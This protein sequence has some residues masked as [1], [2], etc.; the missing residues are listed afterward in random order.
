MTCP[1]FNGD[2]P[3]MWRANCEVYFDVY[4]ILPQNWVKVAT[5]N[6]CG[7]AA[8]WLQSVRNQLIGI[9]WSDLCEKVCARFSRD[10][11]QALIRQWIHIKQNTSVGDYVERFDSVMHQ[12][13]A[14]EST[15]P[16]I[17]F[18]TKFME[19]LRDDI[20]SMVM[21]QRPQDL[22]SACSLA[23]LQEEA[24]GGTKSVTF[25]NVNSP[26]FVKSPSRSNINSASP[27]SSTIT[28]PT[29]S[30]E[31]KRMPEA[32][33]G[34][35]DRVAALK[36]Y[37]RSKGLCFTCG[38]KWGRDHKC[39]TSV[40]LHVVEELLDALQSDMDIISTAGSIPEG[41]E[42]VLMSISAQALHGTETSKSNRL[43][44]WIQDKEM[45]ML[46]D[47]GSTH[48]F[49][50]EQISTKLRGVQTLTTP[51]KVQ[52]ADGGQLPCSQVIPHCSWW[53]QGNNFKT[54][55]RLL[56]LGSYDVILGMDW[57][58][59][60]SP[61][62]ID[63]AK[64]WLEFHYQQ[65]LIRLKGL[66]P[67]LNHCD[68]ISLHQLTGMVATE[69]VECVLQLQATSESR[70]S[71]IP[72][73]VQPILKEFQ[74]L[75]SEPT[76]LPPSRN[77]D[78]HIPL[79]PGAKPVNLRPYRYKPALKNEIERQVSEMLESGV[80]QHSQSP[81]SS[82]ALLV[83]KK[84]GTWRLC[85]DYRQLNAITVKSK[86]PVP[87]IEELL[88]ELSGSHWFS[89]LDLRAG[90]H[91]IRMAKGDEPKTAFQTHS[92]HYEYKVMSFGLTGAPATFLSAMN[93]TLASVLR[94]FALVFFD[95]I[96]IYSPTLS[97]HLD[98]LRTVLQLL[99]EN[100]WKVKLSKCSFA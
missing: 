62:R 26:P 76:G 20:R 50:D 25:R 46:V 54:N 15:A 78:H 38:E 16:P 93:A 80:I 49:I 56:Q 90:Y 41:E 9:T 85:I 64:K 59:Q 53:I 51:L 47:S 43:R 61:M 44:G 98:H 12:L 89:K 18:V 69:S 83:K 6:F 72:E 36:S 52:I 81:F 28:S 31:E 82:P 99:S 84:D 67:K 92:G 37:R 75:F 21:L 27:T 30:P 2:N 10:R 29:H 70:P 73:S 19:G 58:E 86:Y 96:L 71:D 17:Y 24:V 87:I 32:T 35:E 11:Q 88:D 13:M 3:H 79:V 65:Q 68:S 8:F 5:L 77:C 14:Y 45:L 57:L 55:F 74:E 4:G 33:R 40:Q 1:Q 39:A 66:Q 23:L 63:W 22:D 94:K 48:S 97:A 42:D 91:Q 7:N 100:N 34:R 95:D 60:F